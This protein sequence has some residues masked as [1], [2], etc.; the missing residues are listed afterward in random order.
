[1]QLRP[2]DTYGVRLSCHS[3]CRNPGVARRDHDSGFTLVE[4]VVALL[5]FS[6][7]SLAFAFAMTGG[8][9][10]SNDGRLHQVAV[11]LA[12]SELD[13][14]R[15]IIPQSATPSASDILA[16]RQMGDATSTPPG[17]S[18][19]G[20]TEYDVANGT[21]TVPLSTSTTVDNAAFTTYAYLGLCY[22]QTSGGSTTC[23][24]STGS[25]PP[26]VRAVVAVTWPSAVCA[27]GRCSYATSTV[28]ST[29]PDAQF[30]AVT[31]PEP[32]TTTTTVE[33]TTT[34]TTPETTTTSGD[35]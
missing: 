4:L 23:T 17:V 21:P 34:T 32:P 3:S 29:A 10:A 11:T 25:N 9:R 20:M 13:A 26:M 28:I 31:A 15:A 8:A 27:S 1:M 30:S 2:P 12:D 33:P 22:L 5:L 6:I 35:R 18:L 14:I 19:A 24:T 7:V 16:G